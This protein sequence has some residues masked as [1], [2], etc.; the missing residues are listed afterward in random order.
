MTTKK[1]HLLA[2][3]A[4]LMLSASASA[5]LTISSGAT[6]NV[7]TGAIVTVQG[8]IT[9]SADITGAGKIQLKGSGNQNVNM[10]GF[11]IPNLEVDNAANVTLTG[12]TRISNDLLFT[13]GRIN[14]GNFDLIMGAA[15]AGTITGSGSTKFA[16]TNGTGRLIKT[17]LGAVAFNFP[18]GNSTTTYNPLS[19]TNNGTADN[20]G[21]RCLANGYT[22]G[23]TGSPFTKEAVDATWDI[24][25]AV[26]GGSNLNMT[27]TWDAGDELPGF[28]RT[29]TGIAN[30]ITSPAA[31][32][33]W[34]LLNSQTA[35]ATGANPY[36]ISRTGVSNLGAFAIGTRPVLTPLLVSPKVFLQGAY[37]TGTSLMGDNLR[38]LNLIPLINPYDTIGGFTAVGSG[39]GETTTAAIA[40]SG[41]AAGND[42]IVDWVFVQ[43][44][45][46]S[47]SAIISTKAVL[48][49]RD[50]DLVETDGVTPVNMAGFAP[51]NYF[52]S[53]RHRNHLGVRSA[54]TLALAKTTSTAYDFT[55]NLANAFVGNPAVANPAMATINP[56]VFGL[57]GGN[58]NVDRNTRKTGS[59]SINDY[60]L[61]LTGVSA[62]AAPG[63]TGVYR[64]EDFNM[65][66][67]IRKTGSPLTNDYSRLLNILGALNIIAQPVF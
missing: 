17:G 65:D 62:A 41:A 46:A 53:V 18:V 4:G 14:L 5:Q 60:S 34:D 66:G 45:Q 1:I 50:G 24:S 54:G 20:I 37:N 47:D 25:E 7:Q 6:F 23:L 2:G 27:A 38:T 55:N 11:T 31:N 43:L 28:Q 59:A 56:G 67:N 22:N 44:H 64:R 61:L 57:Y 3:I 32:V 49:Q 63:P 48:L 12:N 52:I 8:D 58:A 10:N 21:V 39:G 33:G 40:G 13:T 51:G 35:A 36:S 9:S 19:L 29:R 16:V 30:Y 15:P 42:A 26:A